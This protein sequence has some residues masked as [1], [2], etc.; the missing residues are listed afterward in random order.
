[1][2]RPRTNMN[3]TC[4]KS[5]EDGDSQQRKKDVLHVSIELTV[6]GSVA[7]SCILDDP[8]HFGDVHDD[9]LWIPYPEMKLMWQL[10]FNFSRTIC[11]EDSVLSELNQPYVSTM[12]SVYSLYN[13][14]KQVTDR[15]RDNLYFWAC[16]RIEYRGLEK[17]SLGKS[18][19]RER[20]RC[21][22][23][24]IKSVIFMQEDCRGVDMDYARASQLI[25]AA[26]EKFSRAGRSFSAEIAMADAYAAK[27]E[28]EE[29]LPKQPVRRGLMEK[30]VSEKVFSTGQHKELS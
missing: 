16:V 27:C 4:T 24:V 23:Q 14:G 10:A 18:H 15:L 9:D 28:V 30:R 3:E 26:S 20:Q 13:W 7:K 22:R 12:E 1:M 29:L 8:W 17:Y 21:W 2:R 19:Q 5:V 25:C 11:K 6:D